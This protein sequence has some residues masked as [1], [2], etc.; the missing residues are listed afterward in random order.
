MPPC[1]NRIKDPVRAETFTGLDREHVICTIGARTDIKHFV[2]IPHLNL[3]LYP[4]PV[5]V[6]VQ[7]ISEPPLVKFE[8]HQDHAELNVDD[9][10]WWIRWVVDDEPFIGF[11]NLR[12]LQ[13]NGE[14]Q[15]I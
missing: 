13:A 5:E 1:L 2:S 14:Q 11:V 6:S 9:G 10:E 7:I 4:V 15:R 12:S 8:P 3:R